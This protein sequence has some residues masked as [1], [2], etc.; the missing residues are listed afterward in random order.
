MAVRVMG[1]VAVDPGV[2][3]KLFSERKD[4]FESVHEAAVKAGAR[5]HEFLNAGDAV[6]ILDEWDTAEH[7][8]QF[9]TSQQKIADLMAT[10]GVTAPPEI[11]FYEI[12]D[13][14]DKF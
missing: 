9:F 4:D 12:M 10:A 11:S 7:F 6:I 2:M 3:E 1:R 5:H 13:S 14:P 8:Q